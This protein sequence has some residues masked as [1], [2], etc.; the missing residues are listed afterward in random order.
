MEAVGGGL[1]TWVESVGRELLTWVETAG[2]DACPIQAVGQ[3]PV[4]DHV[5]QLAVAVGPEVM[6]GGLAWHQVLVG[7]QEGKIDRA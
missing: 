2:G 6:P 1:L 4:E 7:T 5:A 3:L